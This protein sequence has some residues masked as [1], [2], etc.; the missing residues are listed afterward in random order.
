MY[1]KKNIVSKI[2][3]SVFLALIAHDMIYLYVS[4]QNMNLY[5][6]KVISTI[7]TLRRVER[8]DRRIRKARWKTEREARLATGK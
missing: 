8:S 6:E 5:V 3:V 7:K 4:H 2:V 1:L